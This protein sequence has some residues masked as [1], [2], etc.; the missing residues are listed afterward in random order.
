MKQ[1]GTLDKMHIGSIS[2]YQYGGKQRQRQEKL[3]LIKHE[4]RQIDDMVFSD[5]VASPT[6]ESQF[7]KIF[8]KQL[9]ICECNDLLNNISERNESSE[10]LD[11]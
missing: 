10:F 6:E 5:G 4:E 1:Q 3:K 7:D 2:D 9:Q 8:N 11:S